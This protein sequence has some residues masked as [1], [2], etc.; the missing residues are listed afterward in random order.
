MK[1]LIKQLLREHLINEI[2]SNKHLKQVNVGKYV[3]HKSN[4][5][6]R[7]EISR[8]GLIPKGKSETWLSDTKINGKVIFATNS[9]NKN[10]WF[11]STYNDD[12]YQIDTSKLNNEWFNDPNFGFKSD[13]KHVITFQ[14]IPLNAIKLI[15]KGDGES[16]DYV[17]E[18]GPLFG[19]V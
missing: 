3:Y 16:L 9:D 11:D 8:I 5:Y 1:S 17:K 7:D 15:Y 4:P 13:N 6:F 18:Q 12:I 10:D 14:P 19:N 2:L